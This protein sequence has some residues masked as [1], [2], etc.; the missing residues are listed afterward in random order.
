MNR[1]KILGLLAVA[2]SALMALAASASADIA[3][4]PTGTPY[5]KT[6]RAEAEGHAVLHNPIAKIE[7]ASVVEG[8]ITSDGTGK[9]V[10]G[11]L[12][13]L[14][15]GSP[16]GTCTNGWHVTV[17]LKGTLSVHTNSGT[18]NGTV[19]STGATVEATIKA[20]ESTITCRY[21]TSNTQ[22]GTIT[23]GAPATLDVNANIPTHTGHS[24]FCG[25]GATAWTGSYNISSPSSLFFDTT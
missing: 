4:S 11:T 23:A 15:F 10:G 13:T 25:I 14:T 6:F 20:G 9:T 1:K 16:V 2:A 12:T 19:Y 21:V 8:T 17:V 18:Y 22:I 24:P 3:T 7:C 5:T